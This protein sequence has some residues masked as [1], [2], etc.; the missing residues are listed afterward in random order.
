MSNQKHCK[1]KKCTKC[2]NDNHHIKCN[3]GCK[4]NKCHCECN[5]PVIG[6]IGVGCAGAYLLNKLSKKYKIEAFEAGI[7]RLNDGFTY[8]LGIGAS[9]SQYSNVSPSNSNIIPALTQWSGVTFQLPYTVLTLS[10]ASPLIAAANW[11][12]GVMIGGSNEHIQG[13]Y[14]NPSH[15]RCDWWAEILNDDRYKFEN[16][17]SLLTEMENFRYHTDLT[18]ETPNRAHPT[19][20]PGSGS[21]YGPLDGPSLNGSVPIHR[22][23]NGALQI[24]QSSPSSYA[25]A[26]G[27]AI[28]DRFHTVLDNKKFKIEPI[29]DDKKSETFNSGVNTCVTLS[30]E[31]WLDKHRVRSSIARNYL[32]DSVMTTVAPN[33]RSPAYKSQMDIGS[34]PF[35]VNNGIHKGINGHD[36]TLTPNA[37]IQRIV[38]KTKHGFPHGKDY[39][40]HN[41][42][43]NDIDI[44]AFKKP[45]RPIGVEY[46]INNDDTN[47]NTGERIF[48]PCTKVICSSGILATP[49][50]LMQSGIGPEDLLTSLGIPKLF[51][52]PNM[53]KHISNHIGATLRWTG[54]SQIWGAQ[55]TGT[56]NSNGYLPGPNNKN[57]RK[58]QYFSSATPTGTP[59]NW[60]MNFYD[61]QT[62]STG[63]IEPVT[64]G[65]TNGTLLATK[66][67][68]DYFTKLEDRSNLCWIFREV[69]AAI[70]ATDPS[71]TFIDPPL[72]YPFSSDDNI[73][74]PIII[75]AFVQ[76]SHY[77]G[78]C[79][80]G[81]NPD[82][83]CVDT[84]FIL[85][86]TVN[87]YVCD[88][89]SIPLAIE[90]N[91]DIYPVQNDGNTSRGINVLSVVLAEQLLK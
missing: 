49:I 48:V 89:S 91:G 61:L 19:Y 78:S 86:G 5:R 41:Y 28:Y 44:N 8:N 66:I 69:A 77:V 25:I 84:N 70:V 26:L 36:F 18:T 83:H 85:R 38:F 32:N 12:Q 90:S 65:A 31:T 82:I 72:A 6:L 71:A 57:R 43:L 55:E 29:V 11:T 37:L 45:L 40:L 63:Y 68:P 33:K 21:S 9:S 16:L 74:F 35:V 1:S 54:D 67:F 27:K 80:M 10:A 23:Y 60:S 52:Q 20:L 56:A 73:L 51:I 50:I 79:G 15:D 30:T 81:P 53:G 42:A 59:P 7:N 64:Y 62:K 47:T 75:Q 58:Y 87:V 76:Q 4:H 17:F 2:T 13:V 39:W 34:I 14:V 88:A 24:V 3:N 22:G 46:T